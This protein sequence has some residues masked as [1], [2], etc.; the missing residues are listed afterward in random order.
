MINK[1]S[2]WALAL[3]SLILVLSVYYITIPNEITVSNQKEE[4]IVKVENSSDNSTIETLKLEKEEK[5]EKRSSELKN[6]LTNNEKTSEE[7]NNAYEEL[8]L[9]NVIKGKEEEIEIAIKDKYKLD[10]YI[11]INN[12]KI[13]VVVIKDEKDS[14]LA[15]EIMDTVQSYFEEKKYITIR[16]DK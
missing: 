5:N 2:I 13:K 12:D 16:F 14:K 15:T 11:E 10:N 8:K 6:I 1:Q 7:K 4:K 9:L 3:F